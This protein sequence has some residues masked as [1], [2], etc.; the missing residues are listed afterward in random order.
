KIKR[1]FLPWR[2]LDGTEASL[3]S[4]AKRNSSGRRGTGGQAQKCF[5]VEGGE[6]Q[7]E[8]VEI[9]GEENGSADFGVDGVAERVGKSQPKC[10]RGKLIIV[11]DEA[12]TLRKQ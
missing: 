3:G 5:V 2:L 8:A 9:V 1:K 10:E 12:P 7:A 6:I 11:G 4:V